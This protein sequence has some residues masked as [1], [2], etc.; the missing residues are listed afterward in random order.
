MFS[1][2][3]GYFWPDFAIHGDC[4]AKKFRNP[5]AKQLRTGLIWV[6]KLSILCKTFIC[7]GEIQLRQIFPMVSID[8][9]FSLY[10]LLYGVLNNLVK[11]CQTSIDIQSCDTYCMIMV[12]EKTRI[13]FIWIFVNSLIFLA[14]FFCLIRNRFR[15]RCSPISHRFT[16]GANIGGN[17]MSMWD[18]GNLISENLII[19]KWL[20][21]IQG[22]N[23][24][25]VYIVYPSNLYWYSFFCY[26][27]RARELGNDSLFRQRWIHIKSSV[28]VASWKHFLTAFLHRND[29]ILTDKF[30][31]RPSLCAKDHLRNPRDFLSKHKMFNLSRL[32]YVPNLT[33]CLEEDN[34][35]SKCKG[36]YSIHITNYYKK[37]ISKSICIGSSFGVGLALW[38]Y[39]IFFND[40]FLINSLIIL[41]DLWTIV[42]EFYFFFYHIF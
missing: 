17:S 6:I 30:I 38:L 15:T 5:T 22:Q 41:I 20:I 9:L 13:L 27:C 40:D 1:F 32:K 36:T 7:N 34:E 42:S 21:E 35:N 29:V 23:M 16:I 39:A 24:T 37:T 28:R 11:T 18:S 33:G 25:T 3:E 2:V 19:K 4:I 26:N 10:F 14:V 31:P 12:P 8:I